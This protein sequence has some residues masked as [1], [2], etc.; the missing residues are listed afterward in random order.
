MS[1]IRSIATLLIALLCS[2]YIV[3]LVMTG[4]IR[5]VGI[6]VPTIERALMD[7][8]RAE[9]QRENKQLR[10]FT[11]TG[12]WNW[13]K[14]ENA[15]AD[16]VIGPVV[17]EFTVG[18]QVFVPNHQTHTLTLAGRVQQEATSNGTF[19]AYS[20]AVDSAYAQQPVWIPITEDA[21]GRRRYSEYMGYLE[22]PPPNHAYDMPHLEL[23]AL[24]ELG[25]PHPTLQ[26]YLKGNDA[27][28]NVVD[29]TYYL[30]YSLTSG[31]MLEDGEPSEDPRQ[32]LSG[33]FG[34][35][36]D[37]FLSVI[38]SSL[39][40][41]EACLEEAF[42]GRRVRFVP[43]FD[44]PY[45]DPSPMSSYVE[46]PAVNS[47]GFNRYDMSP[48]PALRVGDIRISCRSSFP[49]RA[50]A[51]AFAVRPSYVDQPSLQGSYGMDVVLNLA[52]MYSLNRLSIFTS[53]ADVFRGTL[54]HELGHAL[55][56]G[57]STTPQD[58]MY[59]FD[60]RT[61]TF[62][63]RKGAVRALQEAYQPYDLVR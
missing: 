55:G 1:G 28:P 40:Y 35:G 11:L 5:K 36:Y 31:A 57:H 24:M 8:R 60:T 47:F 51:N 18:P 52:N 46:D 27:L 2:T 10:M 42:P 48:D 9:F 6:R 16:L 56:L 20:V 49:S 3:L 12:P 14:W 63:F 13:N 26:E 15:V 59:P 43:M 17:Q 62:T 39:D 34:L 37:T 58:I 32:V 22:V 61:Q 29:G 44:A 38:R 23:E 25:K 4:A 33:M 54:T 53:M 30:T 41:W 50:H 45:W 19:P 21:V 7:A